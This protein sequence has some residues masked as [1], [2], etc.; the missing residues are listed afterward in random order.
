MPRRQYSNAFVSLARTS[1]ATPSS[2]A[3]PSPIIKAP[4]PFFSLANAASSGNAAEALAGQLKDAP[5]ISLDYDVAKIRLPLP[6]LA[7][8]ITAQVNGERD[9]AEICRQL[10]KT[11]HKLSPRAFSRQFE[12]LY[13]ALNGINA[14][15]LR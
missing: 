3:G 4:S 7:A 12:E 1:G 8:D 14:M 15:L 13:G 10:G 5:A 6:K 9:L 11:G 2:S